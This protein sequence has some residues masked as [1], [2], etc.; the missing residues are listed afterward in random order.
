MTG[1]KTLSRIGRKSEAHRTY[2][3]LSRSSQALIK[4][5]GMVRNGFFAE[6]DQDTFL[7]LLFPQL[8]TLIVVNG[9]ITGLS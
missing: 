1:K 9:T 4:A 6:N 3:S 8:E 2:V 5:T 7:L